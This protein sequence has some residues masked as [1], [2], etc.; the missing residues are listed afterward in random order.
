MVVGHG[1][2]LD[3]SLTTIS[4]ELDTEKMQILH[5]NNFISLLKSIEA[6]RYATPIYNPTWR[7]RY[8]R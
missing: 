8:E 1:F 4:E 2:L 6:K 7:D 5:S 3:K